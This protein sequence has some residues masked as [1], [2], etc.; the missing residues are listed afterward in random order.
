MNANS[1]K[2]NGEGQLNVIE[3]KEKGN[4]SRETF[5]YYIVMKIQL[6]K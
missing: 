5:P 3:P 2:S 6:L 1:Y 4:V